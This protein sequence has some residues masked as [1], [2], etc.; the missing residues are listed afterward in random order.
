MLRV[1]AVRVVLL[2]L[3][4]GAPAVSASP[5][6][7]APLRLRGQQIVVSYVGA[8]RA[9]AGI[10]RT[11]EEARRRATD[12]AT[13]ALKGEEF[14]GLVAGFSDE[15]EA[16]ARAGDLGDLSAGALVPA[17]EQALAK[18]PAGE[19]SAVP[20]ESPF[21]FHVLKR[22]PNL[23]RPEVRHLLVAWKGALRA[24]AA[25]TRT[26]E[27]ARTRI[28]ELAKKIAEGADFE[29]IVKASSDDAATAAAGGG[30]GEIL[31]GVTVAS[32]EDAAQK[33]APGEVSPVVETPFGFHL[34]QRIR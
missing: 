19:T 16:A 30:L 32:F 7:P 33:L 24:K 13:R 5:A 27:E 17:L 21:G 15:P 10:T 26:K 14:A 18:L 8:V 1:P 29:E 34:V 11:K 2:A 28:D 31:A 9:P 23:K 25:L 6:A 20:V 4:L 3:L 12:V 22:L